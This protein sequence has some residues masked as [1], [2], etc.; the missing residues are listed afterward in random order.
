HRIYQGFNPM[1]I[2]RGAL[3][4]ADRAFPWEQVWR[5][6]VP[7]AQKRHAAPVRL[8]GEETSESSEKD[9]NIHEPRL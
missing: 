7:G 5:E 3:H 4:M 2:L 6:T 9:G 1:S 8:P